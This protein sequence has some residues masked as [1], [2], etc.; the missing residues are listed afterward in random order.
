MPPPT[1]HADARATLHLP[2][3]RHA[4]RL[5]A[6][7][8]PA[9]LER[10]RQSAYL[11]PQV[12]S[13]ADLGLAEDADGEAAMDARGLVLL[14]KGVANQRPSRWIAPGLF[15]AALQHLDA[16]QAASGGLRQARA[17]LT[18]RLAALE[19]LG[20]TR[21]GL[22]WERLLTQRLPLPAEDAAGEPWRVLLAHRAPVEPA[23][24]WAFC[25][26]GD[27]PALLRALGPATDWPDAPALQA[28][29][30]TLVAQARAIDPNRTDSLLPGLQAEC[31]LPRPL[32]EL[33]AGCERAF[34]RWANR[35]HELETLDDLTQQL[36]FAG[37]PDSFPLARRVGRKVT[38][39]VGPPNSGKTHA[40]FERL[41]QARKGCYL[42]PLRLLALEG[43]DRLVARGVP[44]SLLTGEENVPADD[45]RVVSSTIE[46]VA[47]RTPVDVAVI[48]EAQMLFDPSRGWAWTQ[49]IVGVPAEELLIICSSFAV[50]AVENLLGLCGEQAVVR[51][52]ERKQP[53]QPLPAPVPLAGLQR[54][55]AIVAFSRRD[56]LML[57]DQV[58]QQGHS[59]AVIYGALPPEVRRRE[60]ERYA[61]GHADVL[62]ATDA[63]GM[64]LNLPIRR[65]LFSTMSKF[66]GVGDRP[67]DVSETQQI[68]GRAGR[69]G[70]HDEGFAGVLREAEP[71]AQK[72][73]KER[74]AAE[75]RAPRDFK[76]PVAP[77][78]W[79]V[80]TIATR[81]GRSQLQAVL[82]V[83][84]EQL[85]LDNAHFEVAELTQMLELAGQLDAR[86]GK[87]PLRERFVYAQAPVD[88][89]NDEQVQH[90]V[91][92]AEAHAWAGRVEAP[93]FL[94]Q[95]DEHARLDRMEQALR[96]CT[97][98][99]WL[100]LRF[101]G[102]Y[103]GLDAVLDL[104][105]RLNDGIERQLKGRKPL[106]R[107][108][109]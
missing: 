67:L 76:A 55:D 34:A 37:Y 88:G 69:Y 3:P 16:M 26:D 79:H 77:N 109:R 13:P 9:A 17:T 93:W 107:S 7:L 30:A 66:D 80:D 85:R 70:L 18:A 41:A 23:P 48:D 104:R 99:L 74:L 54:G 62:V 36:Q 102:V 83:F 73:L 65:V 28:Q 108:R 89:R 86:A 2:W 24:V 32:A 60:A 57:R 68:A 4:E 92:W 56:V 29:L 21:V 52:F 47:T 8:E 81:L 91:G 20:I 82:G 31:A 78:W 87:L 101:P 44:C 6:H 15:D 95:V 90:F 12:A 43:R 72:L 25:R 96:A 103:E 100:D 58:G 1:P 105:R 14:Q 11:L 75:P 40:A 63:I 46:M 53:V 64:G 22:G 84:M 50:P 27:K 61:H 98:W 10:V 49:A 33:Q 106:W 71:A 35:V 45:A 59:V 42:A 38:L 39:Y 5:P 97:L 94:D 19:T 51:R